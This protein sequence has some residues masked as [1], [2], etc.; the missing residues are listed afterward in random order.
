M[1]RL[2]VPGWILLFLGPWALGGLYFFK[3]KA[4]ETYFDPV[5]EI[6]VWLVDQMTDFARQGKFPREVQRNL[7]SP[8]S[9]KFTVEYTLDPELQKQSEKLFDTYKPDYGAI[10]VMNADTGKIKAI[11]SYERV[12]QFN[13]NLA[14]KATFPA[15]SVFKMVTAAAAVDRRNV[16]PEDSISF[17]GGNHTLYRRNVMNVSTNRWTSHV[18]LRQAFARSLNSAF[19]RLALERL[20]TQDLDEYS[21]RFGFNR[22]IHG[23]I[24]FDAG[25]TSIPTE[26]GYAL[27]EIASGFN[28][29][30]RM[31]PIQGALMAASVAN[32]G[33]MP[34][35]LLVEKL[36]NENGE[37]VLQAAPRID[38]QVLTPA[39]VERMKVL[40]EET[41]RSGTSRKSFRTV[42]RDK[43]LRE[44]E[45]GG[46][47]GSL[48]GMNP[49]GRTD[50]FVGY[51]IG[52]NGEKLAIGAV[53]VH[54]DK[55]RVK[56]AVLAQELVRKHFRQNFNWIAQAALE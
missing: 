22:E 29:T 51:A 12:P 14:L 21:I 38:H 44:L 31:S 2:S 6:R 15:A 54:V 56:S 11:T 16:D 55:W 40:M 17:N 7:D 52:E 32:D 35:P 8:N 20:E 28:K 1:A 34:T 53:T 47:T 10:V 25:F 26:K 24:H 19:A 46:K 33:M 36:Y 50:W 23:D 18:S 39:G 49:K 43:K 3:A 13:E 45:I 42:R 4:I 41:I 9:Q 30:T 27:A 5:S 48:N 37:I